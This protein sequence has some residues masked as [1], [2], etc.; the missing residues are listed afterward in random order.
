ML[1]DNKNAGLVLEALKQYKFRHQR[2]PSLRELSLL[3]GWKKSTTHRVVARLIRLGK[4]K[5]DFENDRVISKS[6]QII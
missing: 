3:L 2:I 4:L 5:A 1:K 6:L